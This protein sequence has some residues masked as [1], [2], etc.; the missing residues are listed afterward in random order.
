MRIRNKI[1]MALLAIFLFIGSIITVMWY[2]TSR[3]LSD[4]YLENVSESTMLDAYHAFEYLLT[5]TSYM[6]TVIAANEPNIIDPVE[7]LNKRELMV[8]GQWNM[9]YLKNRRKIL[10]YIKS[11]NGYKYYISGTAVAANRDC[12]FSTSHIIQ[13]KQELYEGVKALDQ[14]KLK[15]SMVMM[16]PLHLE[17][18][19]STVSS[20]YVLP[21]VRGILNASG[22]I[23]GY[24]ILYFDYGVI[25]TMFSAN[26]PAGSYFQVVN[27]QGSIIYSSDEEKIQDI[28]GMNKGFVTNTYTASDV[29]WTFFMAIPSEVYL[30][31]IQR[32]ALLTGIFLAAAVI[33]AGVAA[34]FFVSRITTEITVL[35]DKMELVAKGDLTVC[36]QVKNNDEVGRMGGT[37]NHMVIHI[38]RLMDRVAE[39]ERLKRL[40]EIAFLQAQ[41]NPHF[42]SNV[43]NN[44][45]WMAKMQHA[46]NV[47]PLVNSLNALLQNVMHQDRE[48]IRLE[49][50][51]KYVDNY[52]LIMEY[53]GSYDFTVEKEIE[54]GTEE[55]YI[56][57]F[58]LQPIVENAIYYGMPKDLSRQ[59]CI[60]IL[61]KKRENCL[62]II[63]EDN[64]GSLTEQEGK[65]IVN[66]KN[67]GS[68]SFNGIGVV[69]V[70]ERIRLYFGD[71]YGLRYESKPGEYTRCIFM[72]PLV[73]EDMQWEK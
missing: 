57:R 9:E 7:N 63:V 22:E 61:T 60:H 38:K 44:V 41:I 51:L 65:D 14:E 8:N 46:D 37:F 26:L 16:E 10:E 5:D 48:M 69:N 12:I 58:V 29:G 32:T 28:E 17:N 20:D 21:A 1:L 52:L 49:D 55:L 15:N 18:L 13:D 71:A 70:N 3:K 39:E 30:T 40:N 31:D 47:V 56:P 11:M 53:S 33:V 23:T 64:G 66:G 19:K 73:E 68:R 67:K 35:K 59:G 50:E 25:D 2:D 62:E 24:V 36:Y 54:K 27:E 72:L 34:A 42:I 4:T 43:L 45:A 6:A